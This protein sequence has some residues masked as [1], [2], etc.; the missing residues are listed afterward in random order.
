[1]NS[2]NLKKNCNKILCV[3]NFICLRIIIENW[4]RNCISIETIEYVSYRMFIFYWLWTIIIRCWLLKTEVKHSLAYIL[5]NRT[6]TFCFVNRQWPHSC[7]N[8]NSPMQRSAQWFSINPWYSAK[9]WEINNELV[10]IMTLQMVWHFLK[11]VRRHNQ[12]TIQKRIT[13]SKRF[14]VLHFLGNTF[15]M[16]RTIWKCYKEQQQ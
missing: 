16:T 10:R 14:Q 7:I 4:Q 3:D 12:I 15:S 13:Y 6:S 5:E 11:G 1:M 9:F 8:D 2:F